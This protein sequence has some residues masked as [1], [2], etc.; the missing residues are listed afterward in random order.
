MAVIGSANIN[1][2]SLNGNG[3]TELA[4]VICDDAGA[5]PTDI[6]QGVTVVTRQF[7]RNLRMTLW[8]KHLGMLVDVQTTGVRKQSSS[9]GVDLEKPISTQSIAA[10]KKIS[11][12]NRLAYSDVFLHT[13][14]DSFG[15]LTDGQK[16]YTTYYHDQQTEQ[17]V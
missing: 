3:D 11:A 10:T 16:A 1:D 6:G 7:A 12:A 2:R 15:L 4:A 14:R 9:S 5:A 13:A 8:R 17:E